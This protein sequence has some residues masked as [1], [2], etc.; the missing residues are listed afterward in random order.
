[1]QLSS[2]VV[3]YFDSYSLF[4]SNYIITISPKCVIVLFSENC[5]HFSQNYKDVTMQ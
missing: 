1:M 3:K 5:I 2:L 4:Y